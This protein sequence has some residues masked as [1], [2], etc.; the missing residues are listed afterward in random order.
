MEGGV[1]FG[2]FEDVVGKIDGEVVAEDYFLDESVE[3]PEDGNAELSA[4]KE[5]GFVELW[6]ELFG[7]DD[8]SGDELWEECGVEAEVEDVADMSY[9]AFVDVDDVADVLEGEEG[10]AYG[11]YDDGGVEAGGGCEVVGKLSEMVDDLDVGMEDGV[12]DV[13]EEVGVLEIEEDSEIDDNAYDEE[14]CAVAFADASSTEEVEENAED[15]ADYGGKD[16]EY[17]VETAG[18]VVEEEA[19]EEEVAVAEMELEMV[20][21][22]TTGGVAWFAVL[23]EGGEA[24]EEAQAGEDYEEEGPEVELDEEQGIGRV[25]GEYVTQKRN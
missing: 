16:E 19:D 25:V 20:V 23:G 9:F 10:D 5:V 18:F 8:G 17:D 6:D 11:D 21:A 15:I 3:D 7:A 1:E 13:G 12:V 22:T 4:A 24:M 14:E 2:V